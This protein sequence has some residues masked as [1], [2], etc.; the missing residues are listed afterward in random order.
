MITITPLAGPSARVVRED[1]ADA[2][3]NGDGTSGALVIS[4]TG[5]AH[6]SSPVQK[7]VPP[8]PSSEAAD[9]DAAHEREPPKVSAYLLQ[10]DDI[11]VLVDC[12]STEDFV[13]PAQ[14]G[15]GEGKG[16]AK[17]EAGDAMET[18]EDDADADEEKKKQVQRVTEL[19]GPL[20]EILERY[21]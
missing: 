21:V 16:R 3:T 10:I 13:F 4:S 20:D 19:I 1:S 17:A 11:R 8:A 5:E 2:P 15:L 6:P 7:T 12:G 9:V 18:E 14:E